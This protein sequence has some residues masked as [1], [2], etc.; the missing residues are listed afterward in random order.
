MRLEQLQNGL[1]DALRLAVKRS[2]MPEYSAADTAPDN[3]R[4]MLQAYH[5]TGRIIVWAGASDATVWGD[6]RLNHLFRAWHDYCHIGQG[7]CYQVDCFKPIH[8]YAVADY[9]CIGL[10]DRLARLVQIEVSEQA[11]HYERTGQFVTDQI[12]FTL[13]RMKV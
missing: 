8:E 13:H 7:A 2:G 4:D 6:A 1:A 3:H 5:A 10:G 12:A 9:Q 11:K